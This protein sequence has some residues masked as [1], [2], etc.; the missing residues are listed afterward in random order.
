MVMQLYGNPS[1]FKIEDYPEQCMSD[2]RSIPNRQK[3][4]F[5]KIQIMGV[6]RPIAPP[7]DSE[8]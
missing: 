8:P 1:T 6:R 5:S 2:W 7:E 3:V 4:D